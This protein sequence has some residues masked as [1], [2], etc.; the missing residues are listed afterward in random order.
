L[1][2]FQNRLKLES[3]LLVNFYIYIVFNFITRRT[4]LEYGTENYKD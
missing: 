1:Q 3:F 4:L 2:H